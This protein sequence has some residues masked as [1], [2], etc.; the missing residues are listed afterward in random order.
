MNIVIP[1]DFPPTYASLEQVD[2]ARLAP[3]GNVVLHTTRA[4][5]RA[6]LFSR[7]ADADALI[8]VRAY[9]SAR[10]RGVRARAAAAHGVDSGHGHRQRR[11]GGGV[12]PRHRGHEHAGRGRPVGGRADVRP[13]AGG[14]AWH[15]RGRFGAADGRLGAYRGPR[16]RGQDA[17][18]TWPGRDWRARGAAGPGFWH[19]GDRMELPRRIR[20]APNGWASRWCPGRTLF[21]RADVVSVHLRN[22]RR[23]AWLRRARGARADEA[24]G[25]LAQHGARGAGGSGGAG[26]GPARGPPGWRRPGCVP[27]GAAPA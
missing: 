17:G 24:D 20:R 27:R 8:N 5:D 19:A 4:A 12:T 1:D 11:P 16:A 2:L 9:T 13:A 7:I 6:E 21:E 3:F 25:H 23:G 22:T 18:R 14:R 10:R 15:R 26:R